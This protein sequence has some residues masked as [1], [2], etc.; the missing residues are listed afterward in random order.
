MGRI[1]KNCTHN[2]L[3]LQW[4]SKIFLFIVLFYLVRKSGA[5]IV[6]A[7]SNVSRGF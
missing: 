4:N 5:S 6:L 1:H 7:F 2:L 3:T